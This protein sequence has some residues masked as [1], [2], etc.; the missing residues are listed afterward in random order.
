TCHAK[1]KCGPGQVERLVRPGL[2][3][4]TRIAAGVVARLVQI[5]CEP[6]LVNRRGDVIGPLVSPVLRSIHPVVPPPLH[7]RA[8]PCLGTDEHVEVLLDGFWLTANTLIELSA[9]AYNPC[10]EIITVV[11]GAFVHEVRV[12]LLAITRIYIPHRLVIFQAVSFELL[13]REFL[14]LAT[15][16]AQ[17]VASRLQQIPEP[18]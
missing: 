13:L 4:L 10:S 18:G 1:S 8:A 12:K 5:L 16:R 2:Q 14:Q 17:V 6:H 15:K 11:F 7:A 9:L 3:L